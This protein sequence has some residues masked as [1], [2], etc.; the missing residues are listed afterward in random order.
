MG[1]QCI[2]LNKNGTRCHHPVQVRNTLCWTHGIDITIVE[3]NI[4]ADYMASNYFP[5]FWY[6]NNHLTESEHHLISRLYNQVFKGKT[7]EHDRSK[8]FDWINQI[9]LNQLNDAEKQ[10]INKAKTSFDAITKNQNLYF[11]WNQPAHRGRHLVNKIE[12]FSPDVIILA[13]LDQNKV[14]FFLKSLG[15]QYTVL[16]GSSTDILYK[17]R[18][19]TRSFDGSAIFYNQTKLSCQS[20]HKFNYV[21]DSLPEPNRVAVIALLITNSNPSK[22]LILVATHLM[23]Q[24]YSSIYEGVRL[25]EINELLSEIEQFK[26]S[27]FLEDSIPTVISGDFNSVAYGPVYD[28]MIDNQYTPSVFKPESKLF[29]KAGAESSYKNPQKYPQKKQIPATTKTTERYTWIDYIWVKNANYRSRQQIDRVAPLETWPD[30]K[31]PSDHN[32][33]STI[34]YI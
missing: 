7:W 33:V 6:D 13:E 27:N 9:D 12:E 26:K 25:K 30:E 18:P 23:S 28:L 3:Y 14:D 34:I 29:G 19:L 24:E 32:P 8:P 31:H 21:H 10:T 5:W 11:E 22:K 16:C 15:S 4:L 17:K 20:Y 1:Y 2:A